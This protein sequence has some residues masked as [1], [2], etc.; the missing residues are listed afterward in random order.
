VAILLTQGHRLA[1]EES[2][3][4]VLAA[5]AD[6]AAARA[7]PVCYFGEQLDRLS[8]LA[9][10]LLR[11]VVVPAGELPLARYHELLAALPPMLAVAPLETAGDPATVEFVAGKSDVKMLEYG[12]YGHPGVYSAAPPYVESDLRCGA[13]AANTY[14]AWMQALE[15]TWHNGWRAAAAEQEDIR[16]RRDIAVVAADSWARALEAARLDVPLDSREIARTADRFR[17]AVR[18]ARA[19]TAWRLAH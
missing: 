5:I 6:F 11:A 17:A 10:R 7:L 4:P 18:S 14:E 13:L 15:R 12:G 16:R 8:P 2:A 1:L 3:E 19:R 9:A